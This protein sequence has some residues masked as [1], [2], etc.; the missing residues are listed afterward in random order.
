MPLT[1]ELLISEITLMGPGFCVLGL[2]RA[3]QG[4]RSLRPI[5]R[6][7][8]SWAPFAYKRGDR[9]AFD[10]S[11]IP[12]VPPHTEDRLAGNHRSLGSLGEGELL[13]RLKQAEVADSLK[14]LFGC[15]VRPSPRGGDAVYVCPNEAKR[16]VCGCAITAVAF[17]FRFFPKSASPYRSL[18]EKPSI[19]LWSIR[20]GRISPSKSPA[21]SGAANRIKCEPSTS[22]TISCKRKSL[23]VNSGS[24]GSASVVRIGTV[25]V[26]PCSIPYSPCRRNIG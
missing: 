2:E 8:F 12:T 16:S 4:F 18:L 10:L 7:S 21:A 1:T 9:V 17:S 11:Y 15:P 24:Q 14:D 26:G 23:P 20:N 6:N 3:T 25:S 22:L 19:F 5:P 13:Q